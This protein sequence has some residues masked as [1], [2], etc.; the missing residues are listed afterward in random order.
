V[1]LALTFFG[2]IYSSVDLIASSAQ[3]PHSGEC[4]IQKFRSVTAFL[5]LVFIFVP[6]T[7]AHLVTYYF[8]VL[9]LWEEVPREFARDTP[10]MMAGLSIIPVFSWY[11]MFIALP[12][13]YQDMDKATKS[14]GRSAR[15]GT[16]LVFAACIYWLVSHLVSTT[17]AFVAGIAA[18]IS[19]TPSPTDDVSVIAAIIGILS[20]LL[21]CAIT[22][23]VFWIIRGKVLAFIDIKSSVGQ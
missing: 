3:R 10:K 18:V 7:I 13:L 2:I 14:Y 4:G 16:V 1:I 17:L 9:R 21:Y 15:F 20:S 23:S 11:W 22:F 6:G 19:R 12:G 8:Y 5:F